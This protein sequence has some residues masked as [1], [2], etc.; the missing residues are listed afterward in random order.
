M[1]NSYGYVGVGIPEQKFQSNK[2]VLSTSDIIDLSNDNK[3][4]QYGQLDHLLT[5]TASGESTID[6]TDFNKADY[7]T[8]MLTMTDVNFSA[9]KQLAIRFY[10]NGTL[11]T[12][13]TYTIA[14]RRGAADNNFGTP[15]ATT[16]NYATLHSG[17]G[18]SGSDRECA[19]SVVYFHMINDSNTYPEFT[20][21]T[22]IID[23]GGN[24]G[25]SYGGGS[26]AAQKQVT[27]IQISPYLGGATIDRGN[28][29]LYGFRG[30]V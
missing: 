2:G 8:Y 24:A 11:Q 23:N 29:S 22:S 5:V 9:D 16:L 15:I 27:G 30:A 21:K 6:I 12:G 1:S 18:G 26:F 3:L 19:N 13:A 7:I 20:H 28:F 4:T 10:L 14:Y 25:M 17:M